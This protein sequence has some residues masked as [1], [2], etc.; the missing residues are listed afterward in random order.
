MTLKK[1]LFLLTLIFFVNISVHAQSAN[2]VATLS[3]GVTNKIRVKYE[4]AFNSVI[5]AGVF[6]N[7]YY[8]LYQ[9]FR[10]DPIVRIYFLGK[11]PSGLYAQIK[12]V[13][14]QFTT[15]ESAIL[16]QNNKE[17]VT[18]YNTGGGF[19]IGFQY[20]GNTTAVDMGIGFKL[21]TGVP[22]YTKDNFQYQGDNAVFYST[23]PGSIFDGLIAVGFSF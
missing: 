18:F 10:V 7:Y 8:G 17:K 3:I 11:A 22:K 19:G 2:H 16:N 12:G 21:V 6:G 23:G 5:S 4:Q 13:F 1:I 15:E 14:G 20:A 9:G